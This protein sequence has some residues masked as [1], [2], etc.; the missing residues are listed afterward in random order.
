MDRIAQATFEVAL[1]RHDDEIFN[2]FYD[3]LAT[4]PEVME[5]CL[6]GY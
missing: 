6:H 5:A 4:L 2:R 1:D 3:A